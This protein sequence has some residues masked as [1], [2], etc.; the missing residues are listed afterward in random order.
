MNFWARRPIGVNLLGALLVIASTA[1]LGLLGIAQGYPS[2]WWWELFLYGSLLVASLAIARWYDRLPAAWIGL[3]PHRWMG[4]ELGQGALL[5]LGMAT[6]AWAPIALVGT[7]KVDT[8]TPPLAWPVAIP[9]FIAL[10]AGE[11]ILFRGYLFQRF[12]EIVGPVASTLIVSILFSLLHF[13]DGREATTISALNVMLAGVLFTL[14][15]LKTG[16]LWLPIAMHA[17]W[18]LA[19]GNLFGMPVSGTSFGPAILRTIPEGAR[20]FTG[21]AFGP[22]GSL[23]ATAALGAGL[24]LLALSDRITLSPYVHASIFRAVYRRE[25]LRIDASKE[26]LGSDTRPAS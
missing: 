26:R 20:F 13:I 10:A 23:T 1:G 8:F 18:N 4:R 7:V 15:Y 2:Y 16:S 21:G 9:Y 12:M 22:E 3:A 6:I 14:A 24:A 19:I 11:E 25:Q 17:A 5:G